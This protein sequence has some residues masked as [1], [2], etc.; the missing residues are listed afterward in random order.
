MI[1][2]I[3]AVSLAVALL[4]LMSFVVM[5]VSAEAEVV[6]YGWEYSFFAD[7]DGIQ[8]A[9]G[10]NYPGCPIGAYSTAVDDQGY[11]YLAT[12]SCST[13]PYLIIRVEP[14]GSAWS[15]FGNY[16]VSDLDG[17]FAHTINGETLVY[18]SGGGGASVF[19]AYGNRVGLY[20][21]VYGN[22]QYVVANSLGEIFVS[23]INSG[24]Y[25]IDSATGVASVFL[26]VSGDTSIIAIDA[27]D[28]LYVR[29]LS[30]LL[31]VAPDGTYST[32]MTF[33]QGTGSMAV[34]PSG[35]IYIVVAGNILRLFENPDGTW[36]YSIFAEGISG[37]LDWSMDGNTLYI[38]RGVERT[39]YTLTKTIIPATVE[40]DSDEV[41]LEC[42]DGVLEI[43]DDIEAHIELP[44]GYSV[45]DID[46]STV[47]LNGIVSAEVDDDE[48]EIK[49]HDKDGIP[50]LEVEFEIKRVEGLLQPGPNSL[51][52][53]GSLLDGTM[54]EGSSF[55]YL[56]LDDE[57]CGK[58]DDDDKDCDKDRDK[59][60]RKDRDKDR[61]W[62]HD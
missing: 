9:S 55:V 18:A 13:A 52:I 62:H 47:I 30:N 29:N 1:K 45:S 14:D 33:S 58:S 34:H 59:R 5:P 16:S 46:L 54:F 38:S 19:D 53:S 11:V 35:D 17:V 22:A 37:F 41:E 28:N 8:S 27:N 23:T 31:K 10:Y 4:V 56:V 3:C 48:I 2:R 40:F 32:I 15:T 7:L 44:E 12:S 42:D 57:M 49:D 50:D 20:S 6:P 25:R 51:T 21:G 24:V 26:P 43:D 60:H 39:I 61:D 36:D